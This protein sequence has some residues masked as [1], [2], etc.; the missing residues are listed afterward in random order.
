MF[1]IF[2][3]EL[4][5]F[6]RSLMAYVIMGFFSLLMGLWMWVFPETN[7]LDGGY[8]DLQP[9]FRLGPYVFMLL[10]PAVTMHMFAE[11]QRAGTLE[12]LLTTPLTVPQ[13]VL[14][15]YLASWFILLLTLLLTTVYHVTVYSLAS[16]VGNIDTAAVLGSYLGLLLLAGV[17]A[18]IG[19][20][21]SSLTAHQLVAFLLS[22]LL[23]FLLYQG[24][25]AW[26]T[27]QTWERYSLWLAQLGLRYHYDALR[28][29]VI[30]S[31]DLLYFAGMA[32]LLL[33]TTMQVLYRRK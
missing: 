1:P 14:G 19:L 18:A 22:V 32:T 28:R 16:P 24:F 31:R 6:L 4:N 27:L 26:M 9:L 33:W 20:C 3:K 25:D 29:G 17:F 5:V 30:D 13:L 23:C 21:M 8:A 7:V 11:E 12:L 2:V 15:K 10:V